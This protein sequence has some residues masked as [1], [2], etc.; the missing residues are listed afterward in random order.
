LAARRRPSRDR[1]ELGSSRCSTGLLAVM[2][3]ASTRLAGVGDDEVQAAVG[4]DVLDRAAEVGVQPADAEREVLDDLLL[5]A[6][7]ELLVVLPAAAARSRPRSDRP[8]RA[9]KSVQYSVGWPSSSTRGVRVSP[10]T[11]VTVWPEAVRVAVRAATLTR[12]P[13][14]RL[15]SCSGSG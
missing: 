1:V 15:F 10:S 9:L 7:L 14:T 3:P 13:N 8:V 11:V 12:P 2:S 5:V 4:R 6:H